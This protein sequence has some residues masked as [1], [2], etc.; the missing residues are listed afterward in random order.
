MTLE[1]G[2]RNCSFVF[3]LIFVTLGQSILQTFIVFVHI[4]RY[5]QFVRSVSLRFLERRTS[6]WI[7][8]VVTVPIQLT[9]SKT[10]SFGLRLAL[11]IVLL[12]FFLF[13]LFLSVSSLKS[14]FYLWFGLRKNFTTLS[15]LYRF[16][17]LLIIG[18][19][20][21]SIFNTEHIGTPRCLDFRMRPQ[22]RMAFYSYVPQW[23]PS[24]FLRKE[25][26][27]HLHVGK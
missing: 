3:L 25:K 2:S 1:Q 14:P 19:G 6:V 20:S 23:D 12:T 13:P 7:L 9:S 8:F 21:T 4:Q 17:F 5:S 15:L 27:D 18:S 11:V 10:C 16:K 22:N 24:I 26:G